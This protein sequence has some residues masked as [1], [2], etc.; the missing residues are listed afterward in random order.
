[1]LSDFMVSNGTEQNTDATPS[2][3]LSKSTKVKHFRILCKVW[4]LI[5]NL[6]N[7]PCRPGQIFR[8]GGSTIF[9]DCMVSNDTEQNTE[10]ISSVGMSKSTKVKHFTI[11]CKVGFFVKN[12]KNLP[13]RP[14]RIFRFG[15]STIFSD[16]MVSNNTE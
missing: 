6:K 14:C 4:F 15:G 16:F 12:M 13:C 8:F 3:A 7:L 5:K 9:S 2:V 1:M 10:A 11:L